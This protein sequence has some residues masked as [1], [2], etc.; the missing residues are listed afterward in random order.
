MAGGQH[1]GSNSPVT[2]PV[3]FVT[4]MVVDGKVINLVNF[5][6]HDDINAGDDLMMYVED[7]P[8]TEYVLSHHPKCMKKQVFPALATWEMPASLAEYSKE[9][10]VS[11]EGEDVLKRIWD[12]FSEI[13]TKADDQN[14]FENVLADKKPPPKEFS[15]VG[16]TAVDLKRRW[17]DE[18]AITAATC[19]GAYTRYNG[20]GDHPR[21]Y[22][23]KGS[24]IDL[25]TDEA[26]YEMYTMLFTYADAGL[27]TEFISQVCFG[28][29]L[30]HAA[31]LLVPY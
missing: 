15:R 21:H 12:L 25:G 7:R 19:S 31:F 6:K 23:E 20:P 27:V 4:A 2:W 30:L 28:F 24:R 29:Y 17:E 10:H 1:Q 11:N 3:D 13:A 9:G 16:I 22:I 8:C 5:W 14:A 26:I 18:A